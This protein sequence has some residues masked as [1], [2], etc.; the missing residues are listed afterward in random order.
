MAS[1]QKQDQMIQLLLEQNRRLNATQL[2]NQLSISVRTV[3][4]YVN[5]VNREYPG[6]IVSTTAGYQIDPQ[7]ARKALLQETSQIPQTAEDRCNYILNRLAQSAGSLDLYDLCDEIFISATTFQGLLGRMR[8]LAREHDLSLTVAGSSISLN[9]SERNKRRLISSL[10]YQ[11]SAFAFTNIDALQAAFPSIDIELIRS[12]VLELLNEYHY[13]INDY[14]LLNLLLHVAIAID[15]LKNGYVNGEAQLR[16]EVL[17]DHEWELAAQVTQRLERRF[18]VKFPEAEVYE[19]ALLLISRASALDYQ[20]ITPENISNYIGRECTDLVKLLIQTV[21]NFYD[22][23]LNEPEFFIR[24][25]LHIH[26]LLIRVS[27]SSP[28]KNPL[29]E[30]IRQTCPMIYDVS[31]QLSGIIVEKTGIAIN[32]DEI[33]YIALHLGGALETQKELSSRVPAV[34]YCPS[35]YNMDSSL[36]DRL[37]RR[38]GGKI[39]LTNVFTQE[40]EL[41]NVTPHTLAICT[42]R[43]HRIWDLPLVLI[44]PFLTNTDCVAINRKVEEI[45]DIRRK[46]EFRRML[47]TL[48]SPDL[49]ECGDGF[50]SKEEAIHHLCQ[51]FQRLGYTDDTF[52]EEILTREAL[53]TTVF[54]QVAIPHTLKMRSKRTGMAIYISRTPIPWDTSAVN[55]II[56]LSFNANERK[57]FYDIFEP[58]AMLLLDNNQTK[59][60]LACQDYESFVNFLVNNLE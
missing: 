46:E 16:P 55:L 35:Y 24:F 48:T 25:A 31:V 56:M 18:N 10:L 37:S 50:P 13:F 23:D 49:F 43:P 29:A 7:L 19:L 39:L 41:E 40:S 6:A 4:N 33:A 59:A 1:K 21:K 3:H 32:E 5:A 53:S 34:L 11:E 38:L 2:A 30:E 12:D 60:A 57:V 14:S 45:N 15:R 54:G 44:S 9:G 26:N 27:N 58:L 47:T 42:M 51:T 22:I 52:E 8:R 36:A 17:A 20:S 28:V